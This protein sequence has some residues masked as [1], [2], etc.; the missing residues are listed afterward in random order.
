MAYETVDGEP[1]PHQARL[2]SRQGAEPDRHRAHPTGICLGRVASVFGQLDASIYLASRD[3]RIPES[4]MEEF[5]AFVG[6]VLSV[7]PREA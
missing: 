7:L 5:H 3:R 1:G 4:Y 6:R 2:L